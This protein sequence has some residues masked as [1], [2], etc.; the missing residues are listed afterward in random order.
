MGPPLGML[1]SSGTDRGTPQGLDATP[2]A[3]Q[4]GT[5]DGA[6]WSKGQQQ[7]QGSWAGG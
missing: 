3:A 6:S 1:P 4:E 2:P 7:Q 5:S